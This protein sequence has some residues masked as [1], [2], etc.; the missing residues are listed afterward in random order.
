MNLSDKQMIFAA[1][2]GELLQRINNTG[3]R[4]TMGDCFRSP[5]VPYGHPKSTH[6]QRLAA[7]VNLFVGGVYQQSSAAHVDLGE[8]WETLSGFYLPSGEKV[9]EADGGEY[10]EFCWGGRFNDGN[11]YSIMHEGVK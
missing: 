2:L 10:L 5:E 1:K 4:A 6:K 7:D 8:W 11:H 3:R 9:T